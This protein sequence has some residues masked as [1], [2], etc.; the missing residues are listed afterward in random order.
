MMAMTTS[1]LIRVKADL[2]AR[3][4]PEVGVEMVV[5]FHF[6]LQILASLELRKPVC[7]LIISIYSAFLTVSLKK[8]WNFPQKSG[9]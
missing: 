2:R 3:R 8:L 5:I 4:A 7:G 9:F 6:L 1:N